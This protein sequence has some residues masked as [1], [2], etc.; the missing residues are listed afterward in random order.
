M[1][2]H[3]VHARGMRCFTAYG[4]DALFDVWEGCVG[5]LSHGFPA[6]LKLM[7][8]LPVQ[9]AF[10]SVTCTLCWPMSKALPLLTT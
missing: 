4:G 8:L 1:N 6:E 7:Q 9:R 10:G 2:G 3:S 5:M